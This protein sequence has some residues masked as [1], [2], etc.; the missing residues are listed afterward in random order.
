MGGADFVPGISGGTVALMLGI[1]ER[2]VFAL[3]DI[4]LSLFVDLLR[5]RNQAAKQKFFLVPFGFLLPLGLGLML[6]PFAVSHGVAFLLG[7]HAAF[8]YAFFMGLIVAT[9]ILIFKRIGTFNWQT[10]AV[11]VL[12]AALGYGLTGFS[13]AAALP[14]SKPFFV[15]YGSLAICAMVLPGISGAFILYLLGQ[16]EVMVQ[17]VQHVDLEVMGL[18]GLGAVL[19]ILSFVRGVAWLLK[20]FPGL[21]MAGLTGLMLGALRLPLLHISQHGFNQGWPVFGLVGGMGLVWG[22]TFIF[23]PRP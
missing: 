7:R 2:W 21:T 4:D 12:G 22:A 23:R 17:A 8:T 3:G 14:H 19:G 15:I 1:Y 13:G 6:A 16:Y 9:S 10:W 18:F 5:R 11:L 20:K